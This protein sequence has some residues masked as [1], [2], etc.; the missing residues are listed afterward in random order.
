MIR[1][2]V[3]LAT[4]L[5]SL[6]VKPIKLLE[7]SLLYKTCNRIAC[8]LTATHFHTGEWMYIAV[9][10]FRYREETLLSYLVLNTKSFRQET[11]GISTL[12]DTS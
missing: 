11:P 9:L 7:L 2:L 10:N 12:C 3:I 6:Y 4:T 1:R 5:D 8:T